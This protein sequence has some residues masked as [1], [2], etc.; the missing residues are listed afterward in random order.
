MFMK[1]SRNIFL[2]FFLG[3]AWE[4]LGAFWETKSRPRE[5]IATANSDG[6][7]GLSG[8]EWCGDGSLLYGE[9]D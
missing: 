9:M 1:K 8:I 3:K 7:S 5:L 4:R 6:W 2:N